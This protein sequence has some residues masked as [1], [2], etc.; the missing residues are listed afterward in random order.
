M[1]PKASSLA[2]V[3][4]ALCA[5]AGCRAIL[6]IDDRPLASG[7]DASAAAQTDSGRATTLPSEDDASSDSEVLDGG[8]GDGATALDRAWSRWAIG[9]AF[10]TPASFTVQGD[11]VYDAATGLVWQRELGLEARTFEDAS[12]A[13]EGLTLGGFNDW[14]A[15]TRI[16]L[17]TI[18]AY[19]VSAPTT[20]KT[21]FFDTPLASLWASSPY[22]GSPTQAWACEFLTG[23]FSPHERSSSYRVRCVRG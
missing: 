18:V 3:L 20:L 6:S 10:P 1:R 5:A 4:A 23:A 7:D 22:A 15:P 11:V 8:G 14:R 17:A 9:P 13:C 19:N 12:K 16:E 21:E 2:A